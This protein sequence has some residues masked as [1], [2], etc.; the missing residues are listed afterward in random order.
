MRTIKT[1]VYKFNELTE[2]AKQ[3]AIEENMEINL[4]DEWWECEYEDAKQIGLKI[5]SFDLE[6]NRHAKGEF[7]LAANEV[8]Q[9]ILNNHG[10]TCETYKTTVR[11]MEEWQPIFN[12]YINEDSENYESSELEENL[13]ELENEYLESLLEDY[14]IMLQKQYEYLYSDEAI[15][16]TI[17]INEYEFT[18]EGNR[19]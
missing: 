17:L 1:K 9:N 4:M 19:F 8:A 7:L 11:F 15:K 10:E 13:L 12:D 6:R 16:E 18:K 3:K 5:K 2:D 14:S